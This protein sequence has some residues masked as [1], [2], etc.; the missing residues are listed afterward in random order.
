MQF[1]DEGFA[2]EFLQLALNS[3]EKVHGRVILLD[4][5]AR[6]KAGFV[7]H[8]KRPRLFREPANLINIES[9]QIF[10]TEH[11][12]RQPGLLVNGIWQ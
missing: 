7:S 3:L 9:S 11:N 10:S 12:I 6:H 4:L 1:V 5:R 2:C 8:M